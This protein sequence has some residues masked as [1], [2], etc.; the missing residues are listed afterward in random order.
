MPIL[1]AFSSKFPIRA[2]CPSRFEAFFRSITT[3]T[4]TWKLPDSL[5]PARPQRTNLALISWTTPGSST[6]G[7]WSGRPSTISSART[8]LLAAKPRTSGFVRNSGP[9]VS[10]QRQLN[11]LPS[12]CW[13]GPGTSKCF[14]S[15]DV[16]HSA[17]RDEIGRLTSVGEDEVNFSYCVSMA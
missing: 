14:S 17:Q 2:A 9:S 16:S 3:R 5:P 11:T 13:H 7:L 4:A 8:G 10:G 15:Y 12:G 6:P 1:A